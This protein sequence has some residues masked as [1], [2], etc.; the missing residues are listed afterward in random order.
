LN[1]DIGE[2]EFIVSEGFIASL[3]EETIKIVLAGGIHNDFR[4]DQPIEIATGAA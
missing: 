4:V 2:D 3:P 1:K